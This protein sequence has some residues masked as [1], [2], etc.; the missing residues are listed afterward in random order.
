MEAVGVVLSGFQLKRSR[1]DPIQPPGRFTVST[2]FLLLLNKKT[3]FLYNKKMFFLYNKKMFF[4]YNSEA[5]LCSWA[6]SL[7]GE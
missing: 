2:L 3:F 1:G 4:L 6:A 5:A 7:P